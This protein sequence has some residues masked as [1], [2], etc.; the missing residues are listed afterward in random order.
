MCV[1]PRVFKITFQRFS[2]D[3]KTHSILRH[4]ILFGTPKMPEKS[5]SWIRRNT[6][7]GLL[8]LNFF[9]L[10]CSTVCMDGQTFGRTSLA[11][12]NSNPGCVTV[13]SYQNW[14]FLRIMVSYWLINNNII[15]C[16]EPLRQ[17][18]C[19]QSPCAGVTPSK[20]P[21]PCSTFQARDP[22]VILSAHNIY[23]DTLPYSSKLV[24]NHAA[25]DAPY[26]LVNAQ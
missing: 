8:A 5:A 13:S 18:M 2:S 21:N 6:V 20:V 23:A 25:V 9:Y 17:G 10:F 4:T 22:T 11:P 19:G 24:R 7:Y 26:D 16:F 1:Y 3:S 15:P 12:P 14:Q